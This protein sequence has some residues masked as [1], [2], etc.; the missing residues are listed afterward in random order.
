MNE[1]KVFIIV[2]IIALTVT[3]MTAGIA[4]SLRL[5]VGNGCLMVV[6]FFAGIWAK[7]MFSHRSISKSR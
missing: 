7:S 1:S 4:P 3:V 2:C 6:C 5:F